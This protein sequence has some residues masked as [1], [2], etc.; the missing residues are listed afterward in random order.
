MSVFAG[1]FSKTSIFSGKFSITWNFTILA[2]HPRKI[3]INAWKISINA[4]KFSKSSL[5]A[6]KYFPYDFIT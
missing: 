2:D 3:S 1:K 6:G 5:F 4:I